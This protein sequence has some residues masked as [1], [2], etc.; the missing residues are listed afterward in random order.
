MTSDRID[1]TMNQPLKV[2]APLPCEIY[3]FLVSGAMRGGHVR[4]Q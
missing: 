3:D 2:P 4:Y 1:Q